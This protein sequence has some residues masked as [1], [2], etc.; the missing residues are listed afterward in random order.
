MYVQCIYFSD[1]QGCVMIKKFRWLPLFSMNA[2]YFLLPQRD[3]EM[4]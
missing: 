1:L 2:K 4:S 3:Y